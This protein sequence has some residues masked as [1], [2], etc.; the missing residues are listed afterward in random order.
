VFVNTQCICGNE[1]APFCV[2]CV[3]N[4][5]LDQKVTDYVVTLTC[6]RECFNSVSWQRWC[7]S[8][9]IGSEQWPPSRQSSRGSWCSLCPSRWIWMCHVIRC[10]RRNTSTAS[11][12]AAC[13][14]QTH[15]K[16]H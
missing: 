10:L 6:L 7:H 9:G 3:R 2:Q 11:R 1:K 16:L 15:K 14:L 8:R 12:F 13:L 4:H 5:S